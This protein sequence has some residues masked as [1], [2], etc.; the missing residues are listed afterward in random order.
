MIAAIL[1][2]SLRLAIVVL[3][4]VKVTRFGHMLNFLQRL[5]L[6]L[7]GGSGFLTIPVILDVYKEGT[8]FDIWAGMAM[9]FG[10]GLYLWGT[11]LRNAR[12]DKR[13]EEALAAARAHF[14]GKAQ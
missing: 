13:N 14:A 1:A 11:I 12:H 2:A 5:G 7:M 3:I 4:S 9:S 8:P 10:I 6:G